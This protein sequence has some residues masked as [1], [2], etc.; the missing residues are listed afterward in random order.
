MKPIRV[1]RSLATS[2]ALTGCRERS[3][4]TI[5]AEGAYFTPFLPSSS[6]VALRGNLSVLIE[7][8]QELDQSVGAKVQYLMATAKHTGLYNCSV[9]L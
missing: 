9:D 1:M 5:H 7:K 2:V 6:Y 3:R 4:L 8:A